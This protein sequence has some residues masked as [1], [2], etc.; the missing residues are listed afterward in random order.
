MR[1]GG[2]RQLRESQFNVRFTSGGDQYVF[3]ARTG[4]LVELE[5]GYLSR[6]SQS[7][8]DQLA[9]LGFLVDSDVDEIQEVQSSLNDAI[10]SRSSD[11]WCTVILTRTCNFACT[12]CYQDKARSSFS[13]TD[14]TRL[15]SEVENFFSTGGSRINVTYF[16]GEPLLE[17]NAVAFLDTE[18]KLL[19]K[20]YGRQYH[21][22]I[23]TNGSLLTK[24]FAREIGFDNIRLTFDGDAAWHESLKKPR[25]F[26]YQEQLGLI[27]ALLENCSSTIVVRF[28][29]CVENRKSFLTVIDDLADLP[30]FDGK[31]I[32]FEYAKMRN[33]RHSDLFTQLENSEYAKA[34]VPLMER[35]GERGVLP[36]LPHPI[37]TPC[38]F[39]SGQGVCI[40]PK[41]NRFRC[42]ESEE[43]IEAEGLV[44]RPRHI[45]FNERCR[46]CKVLPLCLGGC[47]LMQGEDSCI[48]EKF[49]LRDILADFIRHP[50]RWTSASEVEKP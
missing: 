4:A 16:G 6:A 45:G 40:G 47:P 14:L 29:I 31:R 19:S 9:E 36:T 23:S 48:P 41:L 30:S 43:R 33:S 21:S 8:C 44:V 28:N 18:I 5:D 46:S 35:A 37:S 25:G 49:V 26:S 42:S 32:V 15:V 11:L 39:A 10:D 38:P 20:K 12:Y 27:N 7:E 2:C 22:A 24:E 34:L 3:N 13:S 1:N 17:K 50:D